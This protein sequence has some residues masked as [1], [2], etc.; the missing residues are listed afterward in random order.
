MLRNHWS[1]EIITIIKRYHKQNMY[2]KS[3]HDRQ[4]V[5]LILTLPAWARSTVGAKVADAGSI[6]LG[7]QQF[8]VTFIQ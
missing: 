1:R 5:K 6:F 2:A 7:V 8:I 4:F 3:N